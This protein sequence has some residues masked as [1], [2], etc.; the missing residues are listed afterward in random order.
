MKEG[1][2]DTP[3]NQ[4]RTAEIIKLIPKDVKTVLD[5][6]SRGEM[7]KKKYKTTT[8]DYE[9]GA[10]IVQDLNNN[11]ILP[12]K[13][14]SFDMIVVNQL[15]EHLTN[16]EVLVK[17]MKRVSKKYIFVGLPN[18]L[19]LSN[20]LRFLMGLECGSGDGYCPYGH[21]HF[22]RIHTIERFILDQFGDYKIKDHIFLGSFPQFYPDSVKDFL[23]NNLP[24]LFAGQVNYIIGL[25]RNKK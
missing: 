14:N 4:Y 20:R 3:Y 7:F 24:T 18:E 23:A 2:Y 16:V 17:E 6:G 22:F 21:K 15:L 25:K 12:F 19:V 13:D 5:I 8:L 10:D 11:Q 9:E 1:G